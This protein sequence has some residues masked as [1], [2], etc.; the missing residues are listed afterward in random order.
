MD[1][2]TLVAVAIVLSLQKPRKK[3]SKWCKGWYLKRKSLSHVHLMQELRCEVDDWRNY[4]RMSEN[5]YLHLLETV[6]PIIQKKDTNMRKAISPH[7]K[8]SA[9]LRFLATGSTYQSLKFSTVISAPSLCTIIPETCRSLVTVLKDYIKVIGVVYRQLRRQVVLKNMYIYS[10]LLLLFIV[11][12]VIHC[13]YFII[14][15]FCC[16]FRKKIC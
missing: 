12:I 10:L 8:L 6:T 15:S 13:Y 11:I 16:I 1:E 3:R 2:N 4:L 14:I 9:T 5:L 7:E